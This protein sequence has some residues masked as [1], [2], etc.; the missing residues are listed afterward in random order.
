MLRPVNERARRSSS[1]RI[2]LIAIVAGVFSVPA[3]AQTC[4]TSDDMEAATSMALQASGTRYFKMVASGDTASLKQNSIPAVA[5]DFSGIENTIKENQADLAAAQATARS[6]YL[7]KAEGTAPLPK[8]EFLCGVFNSSGQTKNS[9]EF[10]IPNLPPGTYAVEILDVTAPKAAFMLSLVLQ[11][12][13]TD[14]KIGGFYLRPAQI[15]R[16]DSNWFLDRAR[17]FKTKGQTHSAWL[18]F[19]EGRELVMAVPFMYTQL[20]DKLYEEAQSV[21]PTDFPLDGKTAD[22]TSA[23]GKTYKLITI[24]PLAVGQDLDVVVK[25]QTASVA[26]SGQT[27]GENMNVMRA[28]ITKF[29]ELKEAFDGVVARAVEP[30]GRDYG[31]LMPMKDIK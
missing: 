21:K 19:V 18:Y 8:A 12:V 1:L 22:L 3:F 13:G 31:S 24:F 26:D 27:F 9:A 5:A 30:S 10:D 7:L 29:P 6:P 14:W 17:A 2:S 25:Y 20:T 28:L 15:A 16:H 4:S 11:Q 23:E